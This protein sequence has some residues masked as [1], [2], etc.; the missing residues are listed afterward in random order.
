M[1]EELFVS[2]CAP[3]LA[4]L[5]AG[6]M[7]SLRYSTKE[8]MRKDVRELNRVLTPRGLTVL[9]LRYHDGKV[10]LYVFR[11]ARLR[12]ELENDKAKEI[13]CHAG[14]TDLECGECIRRLR[15]RM[16]SSG[17]F[18]HEVGLFLSYPPEDVRGFIE[19]RA[20]NYKFIGYWKVYGDEEKA[21]RTF[22]K[23]KKCTDVYCERVKA[24]CR[25][26]ELAVAG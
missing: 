1:S 5:K 10:L 8:D 19:N 9:P 7:F 15:K 20:Q 6:S 3:T 16:Q 26:S 22:S 17:G 18:P 25:L 13:L 24:G 14:Y 21:R 2:C 12:K 23:Y 11:P 4:G